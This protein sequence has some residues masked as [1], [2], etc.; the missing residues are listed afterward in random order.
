[1]SRLPP[2]IARYNANYCTKDAQNVDDCRT[3]KNLQTQ[4]VPVLLPADMVLENACP[5]I[6][7]RDI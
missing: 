7:Y 4:R 3:E 5:S 6:P 1:M 2:Q